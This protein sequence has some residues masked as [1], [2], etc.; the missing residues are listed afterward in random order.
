VFPARI[1]GI[2]LRAGRTHG[3]IR[4]RGRFAV[5]R[6]VF[7]DAVA[8]AAGGT[9]GERITVAPVLRVA[10]LCMAFFAHGQV[11]GDKRRL[12]RIRIAFD[13][14]ERIESLLGQGDACDADHLCKGRRL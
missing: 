3:E 4:H 5:V 14:T 8:R 2:F 1:A 9:A 6:Q 7:D 11:C 10:K 12:R 13:D